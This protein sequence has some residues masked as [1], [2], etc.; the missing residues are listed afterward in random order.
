[1]E[2]GAK[3]L[4]ENLDI[5]SSVQTWTKDELRR[6]HSRVQKVIKESHDWQVHEEVNRI[7]SDETIQTELRKLLQET[8]KSRYGVRQR[9]NLCKGRLTLIS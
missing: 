9:V 3:H 5:T 2:I 6:I 1:L 7:A 8:Q 4:K